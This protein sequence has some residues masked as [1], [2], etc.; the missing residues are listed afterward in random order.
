MSAAFP[1]SGQLRKRRFAFGSPTS[2]AVRQRQRTPNGRGLRPLSQFD[3]FG[4]AEGIR[5]PRPQPCGRKRA[6]PRC[7]GRHSP[8]FKNR[9]TRHNEENRRHLDSDPCG[10]SHAYARD[11]FEKVRCNTDIAKALVGQRGSNEPVMAIEGR[12]KDLDLKDLGA[13]DYGRFSSIS[14]LICGKEF[15]VLEDNRRISSTTCCKFRPIP[16]VTLSSRAS[17]SSRGR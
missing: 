12:H 1:R 8:W 14:W 13:D 17:A 6:I 11:G 2:F 3:V 7:S 16:R 10:C 15:M 5:T 4:A 9:D